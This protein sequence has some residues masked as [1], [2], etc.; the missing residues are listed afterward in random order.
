MARY[1]IADLNALVAQAAHANDRDAALEARTAA[2][3][4]LFDALENGAPASEI[5]MLSTAQRIAATH[6][7]IV[8]A[9]GYEDGNGVWIK[10]TR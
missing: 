3:R 7:D 6:A 5:R 10:V 4:A 8:K 2:E 1:T 9:G